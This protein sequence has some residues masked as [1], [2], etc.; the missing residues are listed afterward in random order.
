MEMI[1]LS[2]RRTYSCAGVDE[3]A[4]NSDRWFSG[5]PYDWGSVAEYRRMLVNH[6][7]GHVLGMRHESCPADGE[8]APVMMQQSKRL[9]SDNGKT[10][11]AN[12]WPLPFE[13]TKLR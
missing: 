9:T 11:K 10:C 4:L 7:I 1:G 6:E 12:P 13:L 8:R 3:V 2:V 5:A